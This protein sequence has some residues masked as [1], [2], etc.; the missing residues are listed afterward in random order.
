M[1]P[2]RALPARSLAEVYL[3][4]MV[5]PCAAC[6]E[7]PLRA[8]DATSRQESGR[9]RVEVPV[10]C[11]ACGQRGS[12]HF[13]LPLEARDSMHQNRISAD[14]SVSPIID[15]AQWMTLFRMIAEAAD[16]QSDKIEARRLG[17]EAAQCLEEALKFYVADNDLPPARAFFTDK[18]RALLREHPEYFSRQRLLEL[19]AKLP[20]L[21]V[22][23]RKLRGRRTP[24]R[25]RWGL[26]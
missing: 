8:G 19:R 21:N 16:R 11:A 1:S 17:Y 10:T 12:R 15:V 7:G 25:R 14:G 23:E 4:L 26:F 24:R 3:Y 9:L 2:S 5:T 18:S 22:M 20:A 6:E 13:E